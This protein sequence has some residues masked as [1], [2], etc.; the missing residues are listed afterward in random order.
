MS[1]IW[2]LYQVHCENLE[3]NCCSSEQGSMASLCECENE[4]CISHMLYTAHV[5]EKGN[6]YTLLVKTACLFRSVQHLTSFYHHYFSIESID[7]SI[8]CT[9]YE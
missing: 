2:F 4:M 7:K 3:L 9:I 5:Q 8:I 1:L 6:Q